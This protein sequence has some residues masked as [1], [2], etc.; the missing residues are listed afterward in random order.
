[1][2]VLDKFLKRSNADRHIFPNQ[3]YDANTDEM[4]PVATDKPLPVDIKNADIEVNVNVDDI[5][6]TKQATHDDLNCNSTSSE[7][8]TIFFILKIASWDRVSY[9]IFF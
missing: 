1:M 6:T 5:V 4:V 9:N 7:F 2:S 8:R 3:Y